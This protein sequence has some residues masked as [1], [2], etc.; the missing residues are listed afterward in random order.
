MNIPVFG[1]ILILLQFFLI[2]VAETFQIGP[3]DINLSLKILPLKKA[4]MNEY[5]V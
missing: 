3:P 5:R 2:L 4:K 1:E